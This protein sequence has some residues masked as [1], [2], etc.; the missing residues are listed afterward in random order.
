[1]KVAN[2]VLNVVILLFILAVSITLLCFR[3]NSKATVFGYRAYVIE[4]DS[5][6][7]SIKKNAIVIIKGNY[8][9]EL[10]RGDIIAFESPAMNNKVVIHRIEDITPQGIVTKGDASNQ[11]DSYLLSRNEVLGVSVKI[12]NRISSYVSKIR[13]VPGFIL[14]LLLPVVAIVVFIN[15]LVNLITLNMK[16]ENIN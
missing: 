1:M 13:T 9:E 12:N 5:M 11:A 2:I 16:S 14:L 8:K 15:A 7:P 3:F 4:T 10:K 6:A